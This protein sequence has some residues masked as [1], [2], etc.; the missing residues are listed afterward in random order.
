ML[1][2]DCLP[3]CIQSLFECQYCTA[4]L[5]YKFCMFMYRRFAIEIPHGGTYKMNEGK[6]NE[7]CDRKKLTGGK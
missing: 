2:M 1:H 5:F 4:T 6:A 7:I 3:S